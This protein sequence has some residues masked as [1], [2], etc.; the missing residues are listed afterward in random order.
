MMRSV[1]RREGP[2]SIENCSSSMYLGF[3]KAGGVQDIAIRV[4]RDL[5]PNN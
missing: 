2:L 4:A 3:R 5:N 1:W